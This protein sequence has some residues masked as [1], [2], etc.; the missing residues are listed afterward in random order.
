MPARKD[1]H[2]E[3][4]DLNDKL[5]SARKAAKRNGAGARHKADLMLLEQQVAAEKLRVQRP[6]RRATSSVGSKLA[7]VDAKLDRALKDSF[8]G[9]DPIS[10]LEPAPPREPRQN[11]SLRRPARLATV[12]A[13]GLVCATALGIAARFRL[14]SR[15]FPLGK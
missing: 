7:N 12:A 1:R 3:L 11:G 13:V 10:S 14:S 4:F 6:S 9:S 5:R 8:P 15:L 2:S